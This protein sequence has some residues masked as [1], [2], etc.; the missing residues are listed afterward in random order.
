MLVVSKILKKHRG[1]YACLRPRMKS[2]GLLNKLY[3]RGHGRAR[4]PLNLSTLKLQQ[5]QVRF[6]V[7]FEEQVVCALRRTS[8]LRGICCLRT[9]INISALRSR[10]HISAYSCTVWYLLRN[11]LTNAT[12]KIPRTV[13]KISILYEKTPKSGQKHGQ[14]RFMSCQLSNTSRTKLQTVVVQHKIG[15]PL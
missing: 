1:P 2:Q 10:I 6:S 9:R 3:L 12:I 8:G 11:A 5:P 13:P 15:T 4:T 7:R 14:H